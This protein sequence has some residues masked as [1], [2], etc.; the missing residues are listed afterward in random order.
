MTQAAA[1]LAEDMLTLRAEYDYALELCGR[2]YTGLAGKL[3][4]LLRGAGEPDGGQAQLQTVAVLRVERENVLAAFDGAL[5]S[6]DPQ[7]LLAV[8]TCLAEFLDIS[9]E[10][11]L[12]GSCA[13]CILAWAKDNRHPRLAF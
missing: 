11:P 10:F 12:L 4:P 8:F 7:A 5:A 3:C 1:L 9:S 2:H 6:D 13:R